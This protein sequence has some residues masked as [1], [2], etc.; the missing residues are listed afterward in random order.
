MKTKTIN[1]Y[2][3][4]S[5]EKIIKKNLNFSMN[6]N[7]ITFEVEN[8]RINIDLVN[9]ILEKENNESILKLKFN[10]NKEELGSYYI[11]ELNGNF[12]IYVETLKLNKTNEQ[13]IVEYK[14]KIDNELLGN[15]ILKI[16][17]MEE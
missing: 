11:K 1:Y 6:D 13:Y 8:D 4:N 3:E 5:E 17:I 16:E 15:F 12:D 2:F 14:L 7:I 9:N 10:E